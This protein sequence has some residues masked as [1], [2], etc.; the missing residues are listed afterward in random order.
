MPGVRY[1]NLKRTWPHSRIAVHPASRS[2]IADQDD[3]AR[4]VLR[5]AGSDEEPPASLTPAE[6]A[7]IS[8][9][10]EA[11]AKG[12]FASDDQVRAAWAKHGQ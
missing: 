6:Q 12:Q 8:A 5:L 7:A 9:S 4:L 1:W 10:K 3:I 11:A 2:G